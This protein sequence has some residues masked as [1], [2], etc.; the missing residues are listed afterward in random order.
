MMKTLL[1][2]WMHGQTTVCPS[3]ETTSSR[4]QS[5]I[6]RPV[7]GTPSFVFSSFLSII[8]LYC[9]PSSSLF[10]SFSFFLFFPS[11]F[12]SFIF[13]FLLLLFYP[14]PPLFYSSFF[15]SILQFCSPPCSISFILLSF[16][17]PLSTLFPPFSSIPSLLLYSLLSPLFSLFPPFSSVLAVPSLLLCSHSRIDDSSQSLTRCFDS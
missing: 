1:R 15:L 2:C 4:D 5:W 13:I 8:I 7:S 9:P 6:L 12:L 14:P 3:G 10:Y 16:C 17:H 11:F